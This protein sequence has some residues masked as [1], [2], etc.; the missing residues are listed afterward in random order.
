MGPRPA[1]QLLRRKRCLMVG[2]STQLRAS[3]LESNSARGE[4]LTDGRLLTPTNRGVH[5]GSARRGKARADV[6]AP[7]SE[8]NVAGR[9]LLPAP[10]MEAAF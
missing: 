10:Q 2:A 5:R 4:G 7:G 3:G 8:N 9:S 1:S 6:L